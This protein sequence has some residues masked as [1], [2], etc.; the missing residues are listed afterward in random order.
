MTT[1]YKTAKEF[2]YSNQPKQEFG[3]QEF[4][5]SVRKYTGSTNQ[6]VWGPL[7]WFTLHNGAARYPLRASP[8]TKERMK[9]F[10]LG[11]PVMVPC[12]DCSEHAVA[13]IEGSYHVLDDICSGRMKLFNFFVDFHNRVNNRYNKPLMGYDE[14]YA[15]YAT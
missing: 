13:F 1:T 11:I 5:N 8:I 7:F 14:A 2:Y 4:G 12:N 9:G 15:L 10:I 6:E 3:K